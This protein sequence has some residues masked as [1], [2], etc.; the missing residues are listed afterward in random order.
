MEVRVCGNK[1]KIGGKKADCQENRQKGN[2][3]KADRQKSSGQENR[4]EKA[5]TYPPGLTTQDGELSMNFETAI[6]NFPL[7]TQGYGFAHI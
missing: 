6:L 5:V 3:E 1:E 4:Q 7:G 2:G